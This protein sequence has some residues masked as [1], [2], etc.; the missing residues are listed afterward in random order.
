MFQDSERI[1]VVAKHKLLWVGQSPAPS[2]VRQAV[3][4]TWDLTPV[5][6]SAPLETQ[7]GEA[8]L[9][10]VGTEQAN[11][12]ATG[13]AS[14][15][16][17]LSTGTG[18][19]ILLLPVDATEAWRAAAM[20]GERFICLRADVAPEELAARLAAAAD[21]H[22][23]I[24]GLRS[25]L[26][27]AREQAA[28][29]ARTCEQ[30]DEEM[31]LAAKLQRDFLPKRLPQVGPV[32]FATLFRPASWVSGDIYDVIRLDETHVG[33]HVI[34]A[35]GHG[36]PAALLTMFIKKALQT[37]R[38]VGNSY[39]IVPPHV[40]LAE[41]NADICDQNLSSCQFC[42]AVYCVIDTETLT[43]TFSCAGHPAPILIRPDGT[44]SQLDCPGTLLGVL[45]EAKFHSSRI[46][47]SVGDRV[48]LY[49]DGAE[50]ALCNLTTNHHPKLLDILRPWARMPREE[51]FLRLTALIDD[52]AGDPAP[53]D[54]VT[55]VIMDI[56]G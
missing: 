52:F 19:T 3:G 41:L 37:K 1:H 53:I 55:V 38:I 28:G 30:V 56:E 49:T 12:D 21:L 25:E 10:I 11:G 14:L 51:L 18:V 15:L 8:A 43:M 42:T 26:A 33:F 23:M 35:V 29:A 4:D 7:I 6:S 27:A 22:G 47:L 54:D 50:D 46:D 36:M 24:S 16:D 40:T 9:A 13:F 31:R 20:R 45:P 2:N 5:E 39:Q 32:R 17:D 44:I 34:D 48:V